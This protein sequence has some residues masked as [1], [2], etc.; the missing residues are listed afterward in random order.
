M[1]D[2]V[3]ISPAFKIAMLLLTAIGV[4]TI[5]IGIFTEPAETWTAYLVTAYY[6][7]SLA[8]GALFFLA[9]QYVSQSGWS[10]AFSRVPEAIITY[11]P[12]AA[13]SFFLLWFG[14]KDL[15]KWANEATAY[16]EPV[17][18]HKSFYLNIPF[19]FIRM[20]IYFAAWVI[21]CY[22]LRDISRKSDIA[23]PQDSPGIMKLFAKSEL[24][25]KIV[26]FV[27][28]LTF[29]LSSI[30]WLLSVNPDWYSTIF[31]LK[32]LVGAILHGVSIIA[33]I[34]FIL[35]KLGYYPFLNKFHLHDF[36]RYIFM[37]SIIWGYFWFAQFMII[38]YGNIPDETLYYY[39]RWQSGWKIVFFTE[40][41]LNWFIPFMVLLPVQTS[42]N[43][44]VIF[45]VIIMLIVGQYVDLFFQVA[46]MTTGLLK[47]GWIEGG[48][49]AG[50]AGLF[51]L[52][53]ASAL[54]RFSLYPRN[55]P[56]LEESLHHSFK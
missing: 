8:I 38:W 52:V 44:T 21:L 40:L 19:F 33:L 49:F 47:F 41:G 53:V 7:F 27:L 42:R 43:M 31:A 55:H 9:I 15:Y 24:W 17:I 35:Y 20:F 12:I 4:L 29:S 13:L 5:V 23:D 50:Y 10:S 14:I 34:V 45:L 1:K 46:P 18:E 36:A 32:N 26:L 25:S 16:A 54:G 48:I 11:M 22:I 39:V 2:K 37:F 6:F 28:A 51:S 30:D 3:I 56:Y